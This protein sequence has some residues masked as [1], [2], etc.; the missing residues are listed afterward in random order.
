MRRLVELAGRDTRLFVVSDHGFGP[1]WEVFYLNVWLAERGYLTWRDAPDL[2]ETGALTADRVKSHIGM[3]D[4]ERTK[5]F[6]LTPSSNGISI[7]RAE[8]GGFGVSQDE[9][10][11]F[12][13][14]IADELLQ[15]RDPETGEPVVTAVRTR[16]EAY[17]GGQ[18][19]KAPDLLL[20]LRDH[21][22]VSL[23]NADRPVRRREQILGTHRPEGVFLASGPGIEPGRSE[24]PLNIVDV[25]ATVLYSLGLPVPSDL[26][27]TVPAPVFSP[28]FLR[29]RPV[30]TGA[31]T[32]APDPFADMG[33]A[34][35]PPLGEEAEAEMVARL[36]AL[37]YIE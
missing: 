9:Y 7:R 25:A 15:W 35:P 22:F 36:Q 21:G 13:R 6:C 28:A 5:A 3:L 24:T 18:M 33:E 17:P 26:E 14:Q 11:A 31:P 32:L 37:G 20:T 10:E 29:D 30:V 12:R 2:D 27:G 19:E 34:S 23:L 1:T 16:E 4:W 8:A